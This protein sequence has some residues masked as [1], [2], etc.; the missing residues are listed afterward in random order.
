M[1]GALVGTTETGLYTAAR[2]IAGL[3]IFPLMAVNSILA[4]MVVA[5]YKSNSRAKLQSTVSLAVNSIFF[6]TAAIALVTA[7]AGQPILGLF[8]SEFRGAYFLL[9]IHLFG[10]LINAMA[11][12]VALLLNM[13][14]YHNDTAKILLVS[15]FVNII[16]NALLIP[17]YGA[18]GASIATAVATILWNVAMAIIVWQKMR[19]ISIVMPK[20]LLPKS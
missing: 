1:I 5:L 16:L 12:P 19:I 6:L 4:P 20:F 7:I 10:Q 8:G 14:G 17:D 3:L 11:G 13:T 9:L 15:T 2:K 18:V